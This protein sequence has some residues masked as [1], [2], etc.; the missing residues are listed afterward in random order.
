MRLNW[1]IVSISV[2]LILLS[3][4]VTLESPKDASNDGWS[5]HYYSGAMLFDNRLDTDYF[6]ASAQGYFNPL[7]HAPFAAM[8]KAGW[9]DRLVGTVLAVY[10]S[11]ALVLVAIFYHFILAMS[12]LELVLAMALSLLSVVVWTCSGT[13]TPDLFLQ[14]P[15]F[16]GMI[17]LFRDDGTP[18]YGIKTALFCFG[19]ALGLK[20]TMLIYVPAVGILLVARRYRQRINNGQLVWAAIMLVAGFAAAYAWWGLQLYHRFGNPFFPFF[21]QWFKAPDFTI[22]PIR[23]TRFLSGNLWWQLLLPFRM[24]TSDVFT[25][26]EVIAPDLKPGVFL[27]GL[28]ALLVWRYLLRKRVEMSIAEVEFVGFVFISFFVWVLISGNGRYAVG[29]LLLLGGAIIVLIKR[30]VLSP[31]R[32]LV[33]AIVMLAQVGVFVESGIEVGA[34]RLG[35]GEWGGEWFNLKMDKPIRQSLVLMGT[36]NSNSVMI[37]NMDD[38]S[39]LVSV[40]AP[41]MLKPGKTIE[42]KINQY[43]GRIEGIVLAPD[44]RAL[45]DSDWMQEKFF[46]NFGRFGLS[47]DDA[48]PCYFIQSAG[49]NQTLPQDELLSCHLKKDQAAARQYEQVTREASHY[50]AV[51]E[52]MCPLLFSPAD[53]A[54]EIEGRNLQ[55]YYRNSEVHVYIA[56]NGSV[57]AKKHWSIVFFPLGN[58]ADIDS[59]KPE[60]WKEHLCP[61]LLEARSPF[62]R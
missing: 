38:K 20:L 19:L 43:A 15:V 53:N 30:L 60:E 55:K 21:N 31:W 18:G 32:W 56:A 59:A 39:S 22:E 23:D 1:G 57:L 17:L 36:A 13:S 5:Y 35:K 8:V 34:F 6:G 61:M 11:I 62:S 28:A 2:V 33:I 41:Y 51:I 27:I 14:I 25:Y 52:A 50:Y 7:V 54:I 24:A 3:V 45:D 9:P 46:E 40:N 4:A 47:W 12:G 26:I 42:E 49:Q 44:R 58:V 48:Q 29:L 16:I 10:S 37:R